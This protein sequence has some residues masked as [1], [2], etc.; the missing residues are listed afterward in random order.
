MDRDLFNY[1]YIDVVRSRF[2]KSC[3]LGQLYLNDVLQCYTLEPPVRSRYG[4]IEPGE[5]DLRLDIVSPKYRFRYPYRSFCSGKLPRIM[6]IP[7]RD[8]LL[9]H[10]GNKPEDT[11][12]CVLVGKQIGYDCCSLLDSTRAF[13]DLYNKLRKLVFPIKIVFSNVSE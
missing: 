11:L 9:I 6:D 5:Y 12:G 13:I 2:T 4:L 10:I 3:T 1:N 8:G 7:R